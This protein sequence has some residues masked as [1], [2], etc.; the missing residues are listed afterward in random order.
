VHIKAPNLLL[1]KYEKAQEKKKEKRKKK[2]EK[3]NLLPLATKIPTYLF[4]RAL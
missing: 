4:I 2:K 1:Q 3:E